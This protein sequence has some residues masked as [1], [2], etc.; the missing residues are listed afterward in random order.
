MFYIP[1]RPESVIWGDPIA[2][3]GHDLYWN[4]DDYFTEECPGSEYTPQEGFLI[5]KLADLKG[6]N[7]GNVTATGLGYRNEFM[8]AVSGIFLPKE[9]DFTYVRTFSQNAVEHGISPARISESDAQGLESNLMIDLEDKEAVHRRLKRV[10]VYDFFKK[11]DL[12]I[13]FLG[14]VVTYVR[15]S[16]SL[17]RTEMVMHRNFL[18]TARIIRDDMDSALATRN[19]FNA[20][21]ITIEAY[22]DHYQRLFASIALLGCMPED[23]NEK[24]IPV[25]KFSQRARQ[26]QGN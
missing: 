6:E 9:G 12:E 7:H 11:A 2:S 4:P 23:F 17:L 8:C 21:N 15:S 13:E 22:K 18:R 10:G 20:D 5:A 16:D 3:A 26:F 14:G 1:E 25:N 19:M 24:L